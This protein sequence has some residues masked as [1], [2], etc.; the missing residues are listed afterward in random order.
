MRKW[1]AV[2]ENSTPSKCVFFM[3]GLVDTY[4]LLIILVVSIKKQVF[5]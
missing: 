5:L 4:I 3:N 2:P 1:L